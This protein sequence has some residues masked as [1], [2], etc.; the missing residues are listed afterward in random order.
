MVRLFADS[1]PGWCGCLS[2]FFGFGDQTYL[3]GR[4]AFVVETRAE[5]FQL[6]GRGGRSR[7]LGVGEVD[8]IGRNG[9]NRTGLIPA[10][11]LDYGQDLKV[12]F[13]EF[14]R[15]QESTLDESRD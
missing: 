5:R 14:R 11:V 6:H 9:A 4:L 15:G 13:G 10:V 7:G 1:G 3:Q 2:G 12:N 8:G